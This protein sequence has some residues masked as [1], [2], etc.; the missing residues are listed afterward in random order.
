MRWDGSVLAPDTG[1]YE[2]IVRTENGARLWVNDPKNA[3]IDAWVTTGP[4][5]REIRKSIFLL[6]GRA[7]PLALEHFKFQDKSAS[8]ELRWKPPHGV[9]E[10]IPRRTAP[11]AKLAGR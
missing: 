1:S 10:T 2:F 6:G 9:E 7:Y 5:V 11:A 3:F 8:I 4:E